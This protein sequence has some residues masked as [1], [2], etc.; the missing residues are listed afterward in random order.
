MEDKLKVKIILG[1][2]RPQ[3]FSEIPGAWLMEVLKARPEV[4]AE[5]LDLRDY[6]LP[7]FEEPVSPSSKK[8]PYTHPEVVRWTAKVAQADAFI[9]VAP[10]Y[11][12]GYP[13][14]L[15][16]AFDYVFQEW[17]RKP[18]AFV[19]Y[20]SA[21]G[22]RSVQQLR[23]VAIELSLVPIRNSIHM[24][25]DTVMAGRKDPKEAFKPFEQK[26]SGLIDQL[27]SYARMLK[28]ARGGGMI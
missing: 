21:M 28:Q 4:E 16:N 11:N 25:W 20:G 24:P 15:K 26:A 23:Q 12:H 8:E 9:V 27:L 19:A 17:G 7:F 22:A 14:V 1:S 2:T 13:A 18:I 6:K 3:R 5:T 10:E